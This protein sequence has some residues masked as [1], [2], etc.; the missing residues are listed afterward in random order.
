M[1]KFPRGRSLCVSG[2]LTVLVSSLAA[3]PALAATAPVD[4]SSCTQ[5]QLSQPFLSAGDTNWYTL[6]PG[7]AADNFGGGGWTLTGGAKITSEKLADAHTGSV[8]DLPSGSEAI[9]P[10]MCVASTYPTARMMVRDAIG[11]EGVSFQVS[12]AGT[13][14]WDNARNTGHVHGNH[15]DWTLSNPVNIHPGNLPGWQLVR[16]TFIPGGH[17]SDFKIYDFYVDP[18]M[19]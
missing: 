11:N 4:T 1:R 9:S 3:S 2:A 12:Y 10:V 14:T 15:T 16:F 6:A 5:P 18:R 19:T 17:A 7:Q 8:L 13:K